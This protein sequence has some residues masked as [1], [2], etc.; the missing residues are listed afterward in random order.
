[1]QDA[2]IRVSSP[3]TQGNGRRTLRARHGRCSGPCSAFTPFRYSLDDAVASRARG[4]DPRHHQREIVLG[5]LLAE[6]TLDSP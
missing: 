1:V 2:T 4:N 6:K 3:L 5:R